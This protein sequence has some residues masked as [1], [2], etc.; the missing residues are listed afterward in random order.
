MHMTALPEHVPP[1]QVSL[2]V[3]LLPSLQGAVFATWLHVPAP[4]Q[5]SS[6][7]GFVSAGVHAAPAASYWQVD[8][9]QSPSTVLPSSHCSPGSM[10][11]LPH[12]MLPGQKPPG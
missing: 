4:S 11:P 8:E 9:Q 5:T 2:C 1:W 6:V 7:H 10:M 3:Q 12:G